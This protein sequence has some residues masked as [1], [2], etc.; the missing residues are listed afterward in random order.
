MIGLK[1]NQTC[2]W[3]A[4]HLGTEKTVS[5]SGYRTGEK[6]EKYSKPVCMHAS[7]SPASGQ[8]KIEQF[9]NFDDYTKVIIT[10]D[11][12]CPIDENSVLWVDEKNTSNPHDYIVKHI[13]K[14]LNVIS[15]AIDKVKVH[16]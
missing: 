12:S 7:I 1:R 2:F 16:D 8:S 3:Y 13:A 14:S 4:L 11:M 15:Y 9:G 10:T 6:K 5:P